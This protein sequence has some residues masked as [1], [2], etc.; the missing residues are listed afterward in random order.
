M[1]FC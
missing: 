1:G